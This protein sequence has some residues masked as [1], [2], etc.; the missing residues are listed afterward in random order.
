MKNH[1]DKDLLKC[2][3]DNIYLFKTQQE[4]FTSKQ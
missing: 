2:A 4:Y 1:I 3:K